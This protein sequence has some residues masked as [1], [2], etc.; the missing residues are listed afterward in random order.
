MLAEI[1]AE[2]KKMLPQFSR[3]DSPIRH[4]KAVECHHEV[5]C[6]L[7]ESHH[8]KEREIYIYARCFSNNDDFIKICSC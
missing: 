2:G 6:L 5:P 3:R 8:F 4:D 1:P 7:G